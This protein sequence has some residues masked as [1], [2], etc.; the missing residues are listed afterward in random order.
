VLFGGYTIRCDAMHDVITYIISLWI[1]TI[2][3]DIDRCNGYNH[4]DEYLTSSDR[5]NGAYE[6][7]FD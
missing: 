7:C 4:H 5:N 6:K 2:V 1:M 3:V